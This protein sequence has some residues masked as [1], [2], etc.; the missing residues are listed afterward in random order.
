M[1]IPETVI[2]LRPITER[3]N[4][5]DDRFVMSLSVMKYLRDEQVVGQATLLDGGPFWLCV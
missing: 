2:H 4:A 5:V 1:H 3:M